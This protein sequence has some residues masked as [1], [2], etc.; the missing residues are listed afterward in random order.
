MHT[1]QSLKAQLAQMGIDPRGTL[2][3]HSSMKA[4]GEVEGRADTVLDALCDYMKDGLLIFPTHT[5]DAITRERNVMEV[6]TEPCCV[7]I[8]PELFRKRPGVVRSFHPTHSV[9]A[10]GREAEAYVAGEENARTPCWRGGCWGKLYD[11]QAQILF[12][13]CPLKRNTFLHGVEEWCDIP[14][15]LWEE[16]ED[17]YV[18]APD[19]TRYYTP[20]NRH[21]NSNPSEHYD[22]M[23]PLFAQEGAVSY[24]F[25]GDAKCILGKAREMADITAGCLKRNPRLF[26]DDAPLTPED[27]NEKP[28]KGVFIMEKK[29]KIA[30]IGCG[31]ISGSHL[32]AYA[33]NP[34]VEIYAL[35][36]INEKNLKRRAEEYG[37]TRLYADKDQMLRELPEIDA[38]SVCT[39]N[40]A[41]AECAIAA[42]NAGK[43]V[44]CEKPMAMNAA[45]AQE[46]LE[47]ARRNNRL[48]MIGFVRRFG[49]DCAILKDFID[50][51][52]MGE[53][54]YAKAT[55][56]RRKG[57]PGGWFGDKSRS[58]GGPLID[59]G[60]HV[61]DL[62]R[63]LMGNPKPVSIYGATF[64]KLGDRAEVKGAT[65]YQSASRT[66][67]VKDIFDVEDMATAMVRYDNGAVLQVEASFSLNIEKDT[68]TI[69]LFGT[70]AGAKL[71][72]E[73][74]LY[75]EINGYMANVK[76]DAPTALSFNGLF[77][78][79][80]NHF[81]DCV[82]TGAPCRNP[83]EDGVELM[84]ILDGIYESARTGHEVVLG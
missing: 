26:D 79:E 76:L 4:I 31:N 24:G 16:A 18:L 82:R 52:Q 10:L 66:E 68:G 47:T 17:Y 84:R 12:V 69:E 56:L 1:Y 59:L 83:A 5:W 75:N 25:L 77:D 32:Q 78:N 33:K 35:C 65:G 22:K 54:Y 37:V 7:G 19:G 21:N 63:Y 43:H 46:M 49:N 23:E 80:V 3:V 40:A 55:Y 73:L 13:G 72:P 81:V 15:R 6:A 27:F 51:G 42:L 44:L 58:G 64:H 61:I 38:V 14:G 48:L 62:T 74:T 20:Q 9:A 60:V 39:W 71:D 36:D 57:C 8:L 34:A 28:Q 41:H 29:L 50:H 70:K 2:L 53:L 11:R 45:Q 30:V 67:G